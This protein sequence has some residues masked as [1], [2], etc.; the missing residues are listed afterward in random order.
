MKSIL[1]ML[2]DSKEITLKRMSIDTQNNFKGVISSGGQW[3]VAVGSRYIL[4][5]GTGSLKKEDIMES[6][7]HI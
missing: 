7:I 3:L 2:I 6:K 1:N 5:F 4:F